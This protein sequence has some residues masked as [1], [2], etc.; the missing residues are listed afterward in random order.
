MYL[1]F[2]TFAK[3]L[4]YCQR[5]QQQDVLVARLARCV[6]PHSSYIEN[7]DRFKEGWEING[8]KAAV[9]KLLACKRNFVLQEN[10]EA[11]SQ[12]VI[13]NFRMGVV[14]LID[15]AKR[16]NAIVALLNIIRMDDNIDGGN[17]WN[18]KRFFDVDKEQLFKKSEYYFYDFLG[19]VLLYVVYGNVDNIRGETCVKD[20][21]SNYIE[22][23]TNDYQY[24][25][26]WSSENQ[27]LSLECVKIANDFTLA[28]SQYKIQ[29]FLSNV[30]P[31]SLMDS[32]WLELCENFLEH[33][34]KTIIKFDD[35]K[36]R[37][38]G[39]TFQKTNEFSQELKRYT[40]F[41]CRA[42]R[43]YY[44][45]GTVYAVPIQRDEIPIVLTGFS[46]IA[47]EYRYKSFS[48]RTIEYRQGLIDIYKQIISHATF[49]W[50]Q[51]AN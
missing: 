12:D 6:D 18:F 26:E 9:S 17:Q 10:K 37:K 44:G 40:E 23:L 48:E 25:L 28:I 14:P 46:K 21:T 43:P 22:I 31:S 11:N 3:I 51:K 42:T 50:D 1:C 27:K 7:A 4:Y 30:D 2:G 29:C 16:K 19:R 24:E 33:I 47:E 13:E 20:I 35:N 45:K 32:K 49:Y 5:Q 39:F 34:E 36:V 38:S 15:E 41:L 8:D